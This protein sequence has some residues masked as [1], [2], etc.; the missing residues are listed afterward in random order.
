MMFSTR[1]Q[2]GWGGVQWVKNKQTETEFGRVFFPQPCWLVVVLR[3]KPCI[4]LMGLKPSW[5]LRFCQ[6]MF[7]TGGIGPPDQNQLMIQN[8]NLLLPLAS[9]FF[10][11]NFCWI[12]KGFLHT[13]CHML[14]RWFF[15]LRKHRQKI[16]CLWIRGGVFLY[17]FFP[18]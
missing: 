2:D 1:T 5:M 18:W 14:G 16:I 6:L 4:K 10:I 9:F 17:I 13:T 15:T 12:R 11:V 8:G 3:V 7:C